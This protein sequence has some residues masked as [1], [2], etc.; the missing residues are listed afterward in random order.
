M[1]AVCKVLCWVME[2]K[3]KRIREYRVFVLV[4]TPR[5]GGSGVSVC[6]LPDSYCVQVLKQLRG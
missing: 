3:E 5:K 2:K 1:A 4:F 6:S